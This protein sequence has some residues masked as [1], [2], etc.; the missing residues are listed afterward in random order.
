MPAEAAEW[1]LRFARA[2]SWTPSGR[3][4]TAFLLG[5][6]EPLLKGEGEARLA[7]HLMDYGRFLLAQVDSPLRSKRGL[8]QLKRAQDIVEKIHVGWSETEVAGLYST[9]GN[10]HHQLGD[11]EEAVRSFEKA[12]EH[13]KNSA[14]RGEQNWQERLLLTHANLGA[15]RLQ[16]AGSSPKRW[17][18]ALA[19]LKEGR[20]VG[21]QAGFSMVNPI[22]KELEASLRNAMR[23]AHHKGMLDT[24]PGP[25]DALLYGPSC[26]KDA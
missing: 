14:T 4:F 5:R 12:L 24:C 8:R 2:H 15:A 25:L 7:R 18:M 3:D 10:V 20:R 13:N 26:L 19:D 17:R 1:L 11:V 9:I 21:M 6:A 22:M 23:L 16:L